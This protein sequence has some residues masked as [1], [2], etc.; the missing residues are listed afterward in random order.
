MGLLIAACDVIGPDDQSKG[1]LRVSFAKDA[2]TRNVSEIPDT[3]E[4][5]LSITDSKGGTVYSGRYDA[6]P[7]VLEVP[8][9]NYDVKVLSHEFKKPAFSS[10]QFGDEQCVNVPAGGVANVKLLCEQVNCGV[11][12][13]VS[14]DFLTAYPDGVL[15]LKSS[16]GKLMYG[17]SEKRYAYFRPGNVSLVLSD[18]GKDEVL[19]T[20]S[21]QAR[22]MLVLKVNVA[23]IPDE[24]DLETFTGLALAFEAARRGGNIPTVYNAANEK[25]VAKFLNRE[26]RYLEIPEIIGE[27]MERIEKIDAPNVDEILATEANV[28]E[29]IESRW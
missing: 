8:S 12:L 20:R 22:Q 25:A 21:L 7:E 3:G 24:P 4:F 9:G 29:L 5:I 28:Y 27:C 11:R 6:C 26:I 10:P 13:N 18:G 15:F 1:E 2:V 16:D 17:Y 23:Q 19:M 14:P